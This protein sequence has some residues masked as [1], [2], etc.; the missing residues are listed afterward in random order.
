MPPFISST[1][2]S[3]YTATYTQ[4]KNSV[5]A[6]GCKDVTKEK[7]WSAEPLLLA[8]SQFTLDQSLSL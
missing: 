6:L 3:N 2:T 8:I 5:Q 1:E 4:L 7:I